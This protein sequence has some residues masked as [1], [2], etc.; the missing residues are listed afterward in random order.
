MVSNF[1]FARL[2][3]YKRHPGNLL[4][5]P[6]PWY[7][8]TVF[9][10]PEEASSHLSTTPLPPHKLALLNACASASVL[11]FG[12][13]TLKSGRESPYFFNAGLLHTATL[14][15]TLGDAYAV[16][17]LE[18]SQSIST[19]KDATQRQQIEDFAN[20]DVIFG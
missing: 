10:M 5:L 15:E 18:H 20:F 14:L 9:K 8:T 17:I 4:Y 1:K 12:T 13:F 16:T 6:I 2:L 19:A 11:K 3:P 7:Y